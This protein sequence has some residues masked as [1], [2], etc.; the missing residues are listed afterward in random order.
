MLHKLVSMRDQCVHDMTAYLLKKEF[1]VFKL[2]A[3]VDH[4]FAAHAG[5]SIFNC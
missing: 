2:L 5:L 4:S 1:R 3:D